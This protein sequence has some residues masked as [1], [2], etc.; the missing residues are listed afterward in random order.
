MGNKKQLKITLKH[1]G[2]GRKQN[3]RDTLE[4][5][6]LKRPNHSRVVDDSPQIRGMIRRVEHLV[7]VEEV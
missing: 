6:K 1:S 3:Q 5:L 2:L 4:A 7:Q